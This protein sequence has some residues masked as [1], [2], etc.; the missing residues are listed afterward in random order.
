MFRL[1]PKCSSILEDNE[2]CVRCS[3]EADP[4]VEHMS[5]LVRAL[6]DCEKASPIPEDVFDDA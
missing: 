3:G 5:S 1:C 4:A 6:I 2:L